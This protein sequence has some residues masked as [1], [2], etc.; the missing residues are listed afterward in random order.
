MN[1]LL[2]EKKSV[3][4][5][6]VIEIVL[7]VDYLLVKTIDCNISGNIYLYFAEKLYSI[8]MVKCDIAENYR[9]VLE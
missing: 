8:L 3:K 2:T 9:K 5:K 1:L 4:N 7:N 6:L